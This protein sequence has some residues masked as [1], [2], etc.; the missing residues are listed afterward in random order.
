MF[1]S[2]LYNSIII[3]GVSCLPIFGSAQ[4]N[5]SATSI[6]ESLNYVCEKEKYFKYLKSLNTFNFI[7]TF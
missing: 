6:S 4:N 1:L 5:I 3:A 7:Y 2:K